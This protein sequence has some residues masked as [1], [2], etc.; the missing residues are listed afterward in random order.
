[1][2]DGVFS[3]TGDDSLYFNRYGRYESVGAAQ[4]TDS[5]YYPW[6]SFT[7]YP[8]QYQCWWNFPS[9]P[10]VKEME[11]SYQTFV[12][13]GEDSVVRH[14]QRAGA[15]GWRLDVADEL[16]DEFIALLRREVKRD[17]PDA[18]LLGEVWEDASQKFSMGHLRSYVNGAELDSVMNYPLRDALLRFLSGKSSA[19]DCVSALAALRENYPAPFYYACLNLLSTHDVPRALTLLGGGPDKDSGLT[20]EEQSRFSLQPLALGRAKARMKLAFALLFCLPGVPCIYYGDEAGMQG[21]MDPFNRAPFPWGHEDTALQSCVA[22]W[23]RMRKKHDALKTGCV[24]FLAPH[25]DVLLV[26]RF[27]ANGHDALNE[28]AQDGVYLL[29]LNRSDQLRYVHVDFPLLLRQNGFTGSELPLSAKLTRVLSE[30]GDSTAFNVLRG[31]AQIAVGPGTAA[32]YRF[33]Q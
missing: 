29:C 11:P 2:L 28:L 5:L 15:A 14:W 32:L 30:G 31:A 27:V 25:E 12:A 7:H 13:T 21:C 20:R 24:A 10:E 22:T 3:H 18:V 16:P 19:Q 26:L 23:A 9:L 1:M 6:Y 4:S 33:D 8:D 17:N